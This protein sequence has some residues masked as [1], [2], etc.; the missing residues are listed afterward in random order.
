[1][2]QNGWMWGYKIL[3]QPQMRCLLDGV[4]SFES[5]QDDRHHLQLLICIHIYQDI[6]IFFLC[7]CIFLYFFVF[8]FLGHDFL[9]GLRPQ[10]T[11]CLHS[12]DVPLQGCKAAHR[13]LLKECR[14]PCQQGESQGG[15]YMYIIYIYVCIH[16]YIYIYI[17]IHLHTYM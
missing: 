7:I 15:F 2:M 1:M 6:C 16:I 9:E 5:L 3:R 17:H 14:S 10:Y 12:L 11:P 13:F 8:G 4:L